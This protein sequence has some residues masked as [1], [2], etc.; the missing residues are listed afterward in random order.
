M[1][2]NYAL[3]QAMFFALAGWIAT[4]YLIVHSSIPQHKRRL[5]IFPLWLVWMVV[6][7]GGPVFQGVMSITD[8]ATTGLSVTVGMSVFLL[9]QRGRS[10]RSR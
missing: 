8:A 4:C 7:L 1:E 5:L 2:S 10:R 9:M 6:A 3:V